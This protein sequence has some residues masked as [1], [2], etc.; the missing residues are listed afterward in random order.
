MTIIAAQIVLIVVGAGMLASAA[1]LAG[2][3]VWWVVR[4]WRSWK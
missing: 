4:K 1:I 2:L 3:G